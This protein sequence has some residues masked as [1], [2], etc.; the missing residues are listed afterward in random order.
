MPYIY[1]NEREKSLKDWNELQKLCGVNK[2]AINKLTSDKSAN[3]KSLGLLAK[4]D[5][6][7]DQLF[8]AQDV[9]LGATSKEYTKK[10][11]DTHIQSVKQIWLGKTKQVEEFE[12]SCKE[13]LDNVQLRDKEKVSKIIA[14]IDSAKSSFGRAVDEIENILKAAPAPAPQEPKPADA[15][16]RKNKFS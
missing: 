12:A 11:V 14:I 6:V 8:N 5:A 4:I 16:K 3:E 2:D 13:F 9:I 1:K 15:A 10:E 7:F